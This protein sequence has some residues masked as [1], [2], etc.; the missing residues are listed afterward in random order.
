MKQKD[1][2]STLLHIHCGDSTDDALRST[3]VPGETMVW[4]EIFI[5]GP[6]PGDVTDQEFREARARY[7]STFGLNYDQVLLSTRERYERLAKAA[8]EFDEIVLWFDACMFD[9]TIMVHVIDH[10][11]E[12]SN[13]SLICVSDRGLGEYPLDE[14]IALLPE[15]RPITTAQKQVARDAWSAFSSSDP[16]DFETFL[17]TDTSALPHVGPA[18]R[19]HLQEYPSTRNGLSRMQQQALQVVADGNSKLGEIF[20]KASAYEEQAYLGDATL[21]A[22]LDGLAAARVP[23]LQIDGPHGLVQPIDQPL[24]KIRRWDVSITDAG[25]KVLAGEAD[26]I[27]L[28]GIN[29]WLGGVHLEGEQVQWR[30]DPDANRLVPT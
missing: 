27:K 18:L 14:M 1:D 20:I 16:R 21:W 7:L 6:V 30:W 2:N 3:S 9:Q 8:D 26:Y 15:R 24:K 5:E 23:L 13:A 29:R 17:Q 11:A 19:R 25:K 22:I 10:L 12:G 28:S 4:R